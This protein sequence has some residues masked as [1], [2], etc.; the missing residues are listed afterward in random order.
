MYGGKV[1]LAKS[2]KTKR[3]PVS[4][5]EYLEGA[6]KQQPKAKKSIRDSASEGT[7]SGLPTI[8]EEDEDLQPDQVLAER[9]RS[10]KTATTSSSAPKQPAIPKKKRKHMVRKLKES[11]YIEAEEEATELV[12]REVRRKRTNDEAVQRAV[13]LASQI[14]VPASSLLKEDVA[15]AAS[16]V[17]EA[18]AVIQDLAASE[19]E[20]LGFVEAA[21]AREET[22]S[23]SG[24]AE[25]SEAQIGMSNG[26]TSNVEIIE[27]GSSFETLTNLP[28]S[29]SS[30]SILSSS[31]EDDVPLSK[32]YSSINKTPCKATTS[33]KPD[34]GF[35]PMYPS[36]EERLIGLQQRRIEACKHLS[37]CRSSFAAT[38]N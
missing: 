34:N 32:M 28:A 9:T 22:A 29:S 23:T 14:T 36:V 27:L 3:K 6:S 33:Q 10:G 1:K 24:A 2:R 21:E 15:L 4:E 38:C 16:Q 26:F 35:E 8:Q 31:D 37:T 7:T 20:V 17:V 5:A 13:E 11:K 30:S 18:A 25:T 12:T 19:A